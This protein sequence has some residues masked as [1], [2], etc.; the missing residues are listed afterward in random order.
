MPAV[1]DNVRIA[2]SRYHCGVERA[3]P[4]VKSRAG[5]RSWSAAADTTLA[6]LG[7]VGAGFRKRLAPMRIATR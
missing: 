4:V 3:S 6:V 5:G 7:A 1:T 2:V